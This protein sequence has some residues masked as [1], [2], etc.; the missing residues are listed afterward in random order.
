MKQQQY[1]G[2]TLSP[3]SN[4]HMHEITSR[5][6]NKQQSPI[7]Q[8]GALMDNSQS[9]FNTSGYGRKYNF[10]RFCQ[11]S[12]G[13]WHDCVCNLLVDRDEWRL[14]DCQCCQ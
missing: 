14:R 4:A 13:L 9:A 6:F 8:H 3:R 7:K 2:G 1:S 10:G 12:I 5:E 11:E